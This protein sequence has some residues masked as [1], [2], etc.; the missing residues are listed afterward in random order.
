MLLTPESGE[1]TGSTMYTDIEEL[2]WN[3]VETIFRSIVYTFF[4][5][6]KA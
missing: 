5:N 2:I 4:S 1:I 3:I 6:G